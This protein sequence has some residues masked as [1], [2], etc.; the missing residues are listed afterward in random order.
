[1]VRLFDRIGPAGGATNTFDV[2]VT[3]AGAPL[4]IALCWMDYPATAGAGIT[5]VNDL[6]L[7]VTAPNGTPLYPNG[8]SAR[9]SLNTV[10]T[11]RVPAAQ[12]G[13]YRVQVIGASV[14]YAGGAAGHPLELTVL[15]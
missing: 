7:L 3:S 4:D 12:A 14:P 6:D 13:V 11:V 10:E 2:T 15:N 5:R 8:G 9:D 1:M